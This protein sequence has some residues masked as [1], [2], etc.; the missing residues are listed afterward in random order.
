[1]WEQ[2]SVLV[3]L[4]TISIETASFCIYLVHTENK[5]S[6]RSGIKSRDPRENEY[7]K[8]CFNNCGEGFYPVDEDIVGCIWTW[9]YQQ[10]R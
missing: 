7:N 8:Y 10:K 6:Y 3:F 5:V 9:L 4:S 1:M 2:K